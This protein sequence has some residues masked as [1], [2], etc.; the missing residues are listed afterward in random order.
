MQYIFVAYVYYLNVI[1]IRPMPSHTDAT[2]ITA[3]TEVFAVLCVRDYQ[4]ALNVID[5]ECSKAV[6]RHI[7]SIR[8]AIQLVLPHNHRVNAAEWAIATFKEHFMAAL[9]AVDMICPLQVWEEFLCQVKLTLNL[10]HFF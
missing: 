3:F 10:L 8:M 7:C 4:P 9:T 1:I 5:N 6:E 2:T